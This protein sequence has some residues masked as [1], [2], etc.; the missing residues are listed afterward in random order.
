M[1]IGKRFVYTTSSFALVGALERFLGVSHALEPL[2]S[3]ID[4]LHDRALA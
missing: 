2:L 1:L 4:F 3:G